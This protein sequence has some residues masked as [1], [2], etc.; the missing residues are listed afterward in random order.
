VITVNCDEC[1]QRLNADH[2]GTTFAIRGWR[3]A[4]SLICFSCA[5][6]IGVVLK[7]PHYR[8]VHYGYATHLCVGHSC[9][10]H[11]G[12]RIGRV[13]V[14]TVGDYHPRG[15]EK[16]ETISFSH[17]FETMV[18]RCTGETEGGDPDFDPQEIYAERY[19]ESLEAEL[20]HR[21]ICMRAAMGEWQTDQNAIPT[22]RPE[23][24][25]EPEED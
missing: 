22:D 2:E 20:G 25:P 17:E 14:S 21:A 1:G 13:L 24:L 3:G 11:M 23:R 5:P 19:H 9:S 6:P 4:V 18:F 10:Y 12:T 16:R 15:Q 7:V 8:W